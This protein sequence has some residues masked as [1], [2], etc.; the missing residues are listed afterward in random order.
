MSDILRLDV[1]QEWAHSGIIRAG[2]YW[3]QVDAVAWCGNKV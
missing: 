2:E 1:N 3:F